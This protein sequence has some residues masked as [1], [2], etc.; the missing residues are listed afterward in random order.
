MAAVL[1]YEF[2]PETVKAWLEEFY[3]HAAALFA[4][5]GA[6]VHWLVNRDK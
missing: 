1:G 2:D 3:L 6:V 4:M 5:G